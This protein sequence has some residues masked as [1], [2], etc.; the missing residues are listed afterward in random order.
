LAIAPSYVSEVKHTITFTGNTA[1][2]P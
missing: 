2:M 1:F